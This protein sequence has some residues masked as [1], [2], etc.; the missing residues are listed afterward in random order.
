MEP[1]WNTG[2]GV[3]QYS[4]HTIEHEWN[5]G[6]ANYAYWLGRTISATAWFPHL[7]RGGG[8]GEHPS[9]LFY[10]GVI[11]TCDNQCLIFV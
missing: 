4:L 11:G 5:I 1:R 8:R 2:A 10:R 6:G 7:G 9:P 3:R